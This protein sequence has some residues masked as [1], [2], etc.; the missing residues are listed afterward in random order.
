M[1]TRGDELARHI[2]RET[3]VFAF[4]ALLAVFICTDLLKAGGVLP[5]FIWKAKSLLYAMIGTLGISVGWTR[6]RY[7]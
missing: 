3:Y 7:R 1:M 2:A 5:D 6:W 4:Y